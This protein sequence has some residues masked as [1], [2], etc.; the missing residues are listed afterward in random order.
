MFNQILLDGPGKSADLKPA[1]YI[2]FARLF[3]VIPMDAVKDAL[4]ATASND[5][6]E[7]DL[8]NRYMAYF[9][10][11]LSL[12]SHCSHQEVFRNLVET[13][14]MMFGPMFD[15]KIPAK[16]SIT[17][18]RQRLGQ[19]PFEHLFRQVVK[20]IAVRERTI[21]AFF[22]GLRLVGIDGCHFTVPDTVENEREFGRATGTDNIPAAYPAIRCVGLIELGT[23]VLF[24]YE[25]GAA[26]GSKDV[27]EVALAKKLLPRLQNDQLLLGDRLYGA[28]FRM[29]RIA[30]NTGAHL[31]WRIRK[32]IRLDCEEVLPDGS[33]MSAFYDG[34]RKRIGAESEKVRVIEFDVKLGSAEPERYRLITTLRH[35]QATLDELAELYHERWEYEN[36]NKEHKQIL[37]AHLDGLRSK[38]PTLVIQELLGLFLAHFATRSFVHEAALSANIDVDRLSFKHAV[39]VIRRRAP[40]AGAFPP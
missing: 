6:R 34:D 17:E 15:T 8:P 26:G 37:N 28:N 2:S 22:K 4:C 12:F 29:W 33:Y 9:V 11:A 3:Q 32:D 10:I 31:L 25:I 1:E 21:G 36:T 30:K 23:R 18:S 14:K 20:P 24:D 19:K 40:Q 39:S 13:L 27:S 35:T 7:R 5:K 38:T 16:S